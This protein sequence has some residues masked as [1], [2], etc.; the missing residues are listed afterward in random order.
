MISWE[1]E[2]SL[3]FVRS[4]FSYASVGQNSV[5]AVREAAITSGF[6]LK[7]PYLVLAVR[8]QRRE[9]LGHPDGAAGITRTSPW[10]A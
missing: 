7:V 5:S 4:S 8:D 9:L 2:T 6:P 3:W 1:A 10:R